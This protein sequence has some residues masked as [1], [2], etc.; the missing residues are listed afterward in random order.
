MM[1]GG[2]EGRMRQRRHAPWLFWL[3]ASLIAIIAGFGVA[4]L[5]GLGYPPGDEN[6][7]TFVGVFS[8]INVQF[9]LAGLLLI[10]YRSRLGTILL[11]LS[12]L[13]AFFTFAPLPI[14]FQLHALA[15]IVL[16]VRH[17]RDR[18]LA[19]RAG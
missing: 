9:M 7:R 12:A 19:T 17:A 5:S 6:W 3:T 10:D 15:I 18:R 16:A 1:T 14:L 8:L 13:V 11:A 4:N 2:R